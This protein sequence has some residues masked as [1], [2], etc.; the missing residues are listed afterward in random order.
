M[1]LSCLRIVKR[2]RDSIY[3]S[4]QVVCSRR[5]KWQHRVLDLVPYSSRIDTRGFSS[6]PVGSPQS[7]ETLRK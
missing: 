1:A 7:P 2:E 4:V 6:W 5:G 3:G